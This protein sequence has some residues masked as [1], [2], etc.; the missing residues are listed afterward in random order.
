MMKATSFLLL[1]ALVLIATTTSSLVSA[2]STT[3]PYN[4]TEATRSWYFCK[5]NSCDPSQ[6]MNGFTCPACKS[7]EKLYGETIIDLNVFYHEK[8]KAHGW[9]GYSP[10]RNQIIVSFRG[11]RTIQWFYDFD[12]AFEQLPGCPDGKCYVHK[13][14]WEIYQ[15]LQPNITLTVQSL[16]GKYPTANV[17]VTGHSLGAAVSMVAT[18]D[19]LYRLK[20][21][22]VS[23]INFGEPRVWSYNAS[24]W[25]SNLMM[26]AGTS[27]W[28]AAW[29]A[30]PVV[31]VPTLSMGYW[32]ASTGNSEIWYPKNSTAHYVQCKDGPGYEDLTP[33]CSFVNVPLQE[34]NPADHGWYCGIEHGCS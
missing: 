11:T 22:V 6:M 19:L 5:M 28:R 13:G 33:D 31:N 32:H 30:D 2:R 4:L 8:A 7:I 9:T 18:Y 21:P 17:T 14:F 34:S 16:R 27:L 23:L 26:N 3:A 12:F 25:V 20:A 1:I 15:I 24:I 29:A 10:Q